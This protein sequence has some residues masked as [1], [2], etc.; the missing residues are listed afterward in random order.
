[1]THDPAKRADTSAVTP[2]DSGVRL[3]AGARHAA[4]VPARAESEAGEPL[5]PPRGAAHLTVRDAVTACW[6]AFAAAVFDDPT[7]T[8]TV[9]GR[10]VVRALLR[11]LDAY[12]ELVDLE[13]G[14]RERPDASGVLSN[15]RSLRL[16]RETLEA[17]LAKC[18]QGVA[19]LE[20]VAA[21]GDARAR[22]LRRLVERAVTELNATL[23]PQG[24]AAHETS[25]DRS[26][27]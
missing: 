12:A 13:R 1:M 6:P 4:A 8:A 16:G 5:G 14:A 11:Q 15:E 7:A 21:S 25:R 23:R 17:R 20:A 24:G 22:V 3:R 27:G 9:E 2:E 26:R 18:P 10:R 19:A